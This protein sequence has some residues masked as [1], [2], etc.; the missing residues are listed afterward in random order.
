MPLAEDLS[1]WLAADV[2]GT[3][4][5]LAGREISVIYDVAYLEQM[6]VAGHSP[7]ALCRAADVPPES[8]GGTLEID[9]APY[10]IRGRE[11]IDDGALVRLELQL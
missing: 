5:R 9:G 4:A 1:L 8:V 7:T 10:V 2:F 6:G 11:P 3:R